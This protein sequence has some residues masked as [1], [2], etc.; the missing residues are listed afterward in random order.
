MQLRKVVQITTNKQA[1]ELL[2]KGTKSL[3]GFKK[4]YSIDAQLFQ[5]NFNFKLLPKNLLLKVQGNVDDFVRV[6]GET[7]TQVVAQDFNKGLELFGNLKLKAKKVTESFRAG[8][9][10]TSKVDDIQGAVSI[11]SKAI[12]EAKSHKGQLFATGD[13]NVRTMLHEGDVHASGNT[14]T[15]VLKQSGDIY[16]SG[17]SAV[18]V[19]V[20]QSGDDFLTENAKLFDEV[21][22]DPAKINL[23]EFSSVSKYD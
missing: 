15:F 22:D 16:G 9:Q 19:H 6:G 8:A 2:N 11:E 4:A 17:N 3:L 23:G 13:S 18:K 20:R 7:N 1:Q 10:T 5:E 12:F 14:N 21:Y